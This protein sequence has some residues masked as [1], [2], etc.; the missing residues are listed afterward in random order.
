M[1]IH[2][3]SVERCLYSSR[4]RFVAAALVLAVPGEA[5]AATLV[6][7]ATDATDPLNL[8]DTEP[9][10]AVNPIDPMKIAVVSFSEN[11][12]PN[13]MAPVWKS[14]NGGVTWRKVF[15]I[16]QPARG[17]FGPGDHKTAFG[18]SG[19]RYVPHLRSGQRDFNYRPRGA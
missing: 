9:S 14:D 5:S 11:W 17:E 4:A 15:Q 10:I 7:I 13:A 2:F 6:D 1:R 19:K 16:P 12:G 8:A 18:A 3:T